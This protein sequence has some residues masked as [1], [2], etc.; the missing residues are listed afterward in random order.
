MPSRSLIVWIP[1]AAATLLA[2]CGSQKC[3][4]NETQVC[5]CPGGA[6]GAQTCNDNGSGF[7]ACDCT[8]PAKSCSAPD[9]PRCR[10]GACDEATGL[11]A[12]S[13]DEGYAGALCDKCSSAYQDNDGDGICTARCEFS[14]ISCG[15]HGACSDAT[16]APAC[17]CAEGYA[18]ASCTDCAAAFADAGDGTCARVCPEGYAGADCTSC[19]QGFQ[20]KDHDGVCA[21]SCEAA[22]CGPYSTCVDETGTA[23]CGCV[24]GFTRDGG[25]ECAFSGVIQDP[26][27]ENAPPA[28]AVDGGAAVTPDAGGATTIG[29][30]LLPGDR[31]QASVT[32]RIELP[33]LAS[34]GP[35][36]ISYKLRTYCPTS[37]CYAAPTL[38]A[39][40][41]DSYIGGANTP[42]SFGDFTS[43][44]GEAAYGGQ[45]DLTFTQMSESPNAGS[46][47]VM[48]DD[49][50]L[51]PDPSCVTPAQRVL[52]GNFEADGGWTL[53]Q[54]ASIDDGAGVNGSRGAKLRGGTT[55]CSAPSKMR[56]LISVPVSVSSPALDF[57]HASNGSGT[58]NLTLGGVNVA[59]LQDTG[60]PFES[61]HFCLPP[62]MRGSTVNVSFDVPRYPGTGYC[63]DP[64]PRE[65]VVDDV[66]LVDDPSCGNRSIPGGDFELN[67]RTTGWE[68]GPVIVNGAVTGVNRIEAGNGQLA[69]HGLH[70]AV[71]NVCASA[72]ATALYVV[73]ASSGSAGPAIKFWYRTV[74][75]PRV[76]VSPSGTP[77]P[78]APV[79][80]QAKICLPPS[81]HH[82]LRHLKL[83]TQDP[84]GGG[85]TT[86]TDH[87]AYFDDFEVTTDPSCPAQ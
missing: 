85:C 53:E 58:F 24:A 25:S 52:N 59:S 21:P 12:C 44:L 43:C 15:A 35:M 1:L 68:I 32:Q 57:K 67:D 49:V 86:A 79:W 77:L 22:A 27:F 10:H 55:I 36:R 8:V 48:I 37:Y 17:V 80:A 38:L 11:A 34:A 83:R 84:A 70:Q 45:R 54:T 19:D 76:T 23:V 64:D 82:S 51:S 3:E 87:Q 7:G 62:A 42:Y 72:V 63:S 18:G 5:V 26:G 50:Q 81:S 69:T 31:F 39:T 74:N 30:A 14:G 20:D 2:A 4:V 9:A 46:Y 28:W 16:G 40:V 47:G 73:P 41:G 6:V 78:L 61:K 66:K 56:G 13:C 60:G 65:Y 71:T 33:P 29:F 75:S